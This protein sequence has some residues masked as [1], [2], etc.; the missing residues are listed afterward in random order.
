MTNLIE[1][2]TI[3]IFVRARQNWTD[4]KIWVEQNPSFAWSQWREGNRTIS[5][6][7]FF[8]TPPT[9]TYFWPHNEQNILN[10]ENFCFNFSN[11]HCTINDRI[12]S[13][14]F[15]LNGKQ[16]KKATLIE[17]LHFRCSATSDLTRAH[18]HSDQF[19]YENPKGSTEFSA[20]TTRSLCRWCD[21][22]LRNP[23]ILVQG[24]Q[25]LWMKDKIYSFFT[26]TF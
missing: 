24:S 18:L 17:F 7:N 16:T 11:F 21:F 20:Y 6:L 25:P 1:A 14:R 23:S 26:S 2:L 19:T 8:A 15:W 12:R 9:M 4:F 10:I 22:Y 5:D 13:V 3:G